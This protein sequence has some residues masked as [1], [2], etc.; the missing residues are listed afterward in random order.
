MTGPVVSPTHVY[1]GCGYC[2]QCGEPV[3]TGLLQQS[4]PGRIRL[5]DRSPAQDQKQ[6]ETDRGTA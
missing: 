4:C 3:A 2:I 5:K 6:G 1:Q